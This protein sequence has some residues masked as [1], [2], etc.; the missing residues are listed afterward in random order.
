MSG[1]GKSISL[2]VSI[3]PGAAGLTCPSLMLK[4]C[5]I[6]W[7]AQ[8]LKVKG[9][10]AV[11]LGNGGIDSKLQWGAEGGKCGKLFWKGQEMPVSD[12]HCSDHFS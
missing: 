11:N 2:L 3:G 1:Y 9:V 7:A 6:T 8:A 10:A 5:V 12:L 4:G